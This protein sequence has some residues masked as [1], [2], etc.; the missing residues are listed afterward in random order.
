RFIKPGVIVAALEN[1]E[2]SFDHAV[3]R[4]H[5]ELLRTATDA[6]GRA[7]KIVVLETP[8]KVRPEFSRKD[9]AAGY[10]NFLITDK[11]L[12]LPEFGDAVADQA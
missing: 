10:V 11:A 7:L 1:Y 9:F 3:T 4:R 12:F 5:L 2:Q 6:Q 8:S